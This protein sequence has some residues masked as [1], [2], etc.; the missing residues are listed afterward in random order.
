MLT[1][2]FLASK[3]IEADVIDEIIAAH[4][5][6]VN[7]LKDKMDD[8]EKYKKDSEALA[9]V[10]KELEDLKAEVAKN[11]DKDYDKLKAEFDAYK[12][13]VENK[14]V[15]DA[16]EM[17]FKEILK[18]AGVPE[19][20]FAKIIKYSDIDALELDEKGKITTAKDVLKSIKEEWGDHI[21]TDGKK[22]ADVEK[23][24]KNDGG[25]SLTKE[26]I[27]KITDTAERQAA[28]KKYL[29]EGGTE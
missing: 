8:Y 28:W 21:P 7:G 22:G 13:E 17:A 27:M 25:K 24:P 26:E 29:T 15:R 10:R 6:T 4:T 1:R 5:D 23:P 16:K 19:R 9:K 2:K 12:T 14:A 18:D 11:S 3:G 20:H